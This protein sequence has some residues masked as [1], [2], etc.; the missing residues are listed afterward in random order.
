MQLRD[1][2]RSWEA[3]GIRVVMIGNGKGRFAEAFR[4]EF[5]LEGLLLVDP[6][7]HA[8]RA[9]GLRRGH[10]EI[11][12]PKLL[13]NAFRALRSGAR[14]TSVQGDPWQ[15]GGVFVI[16]PGGEML[17]EH[18][19]SEAGDH[20]SP[21]QIEAALEE[22]AEPIEEER[23]GLSPLAPAM[24]LIRPALDASP[25]LS[26]DRV[27]FLRHSLAFDP[28]DLDVDLYGR[29]CL[30]TGAD[31]GI[32]YETALALADLGA[33]VCLLCDPDGD[34]GESGAGSARDPR[35]GRVRRPAGGE[36]RAA[37]EA[38]R[39]A[40]G[41]RRVEAFDL[42][43]TDPESIDEAVGVLARE[44]VDVLVHCAEIFSTRR[45]QT[46]G[47]FESAF[48]VHVAGPHR[49]M[50][51]LAP[52]L[53]ESDDAR[54]VWMSSAGMLAHRLNLEDPHWEARRFDPAVAFAES[55]RA[56]VVLASMWAEDF[57]GTAVHVN[58]MH[59][60]WVDSPAIRGLMPLFGR[61]ARPM[62]RTPAEGADTI[63]WLAASPAAEGETGLFFFDRQPVRPHWLPTIRETS[64]ERDALW[65]ICEADDGSGRD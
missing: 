23:P 49:V 34:R 38:I 55:K 47:G 36:G 27:G 10:R 24:N 57:N 40:T 1:S 43:L 19:S 44:P 5:E 50:R 46:K 60:G 52:A 54:V 9:S 32:G 39:E 11:V 21:E 12:S 28:T 6:E 29:R 33:E 61:I 48:A 15:L 8:Y 17:F 31:S 2:I 22:N 30:V 64:E 63:L 26:F 53:E 4:E 13:G 42:D 18:R 65:K 41:N 37:A 51:G 45:I 56:Q 62:L 35:R 25:V 58:A 3:R 20:A 14:Q 7:L 16:G 59:P